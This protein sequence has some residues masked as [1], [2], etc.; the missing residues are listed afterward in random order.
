MAK[1]NEYH[2]ELENPMKLLGCV[3]TTLRETKIGPWFAG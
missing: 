2:S 1:N 3:T